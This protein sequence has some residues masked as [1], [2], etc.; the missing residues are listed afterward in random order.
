MSIFVF[1]SFVRV[2]TVQFCPCECDSECRKRWPIA[3]IGN[4]TGSPYVLVYI[5]VTLSQARMR[6]FDSRVFIMLAG[7]W[8]LQHSYAIFSSVQGRSDGGI[9]VYIPP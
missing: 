9:S 6:A 1:F 5:N 4:H 7:A 8:L 2:F 3:L